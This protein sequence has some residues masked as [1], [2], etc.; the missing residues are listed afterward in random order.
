M[1]DNNKKKGKTPFY[2]EI[3]T[4]YSYSTPVYKRTNKKKKQTNLLY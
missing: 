3:K 2:E 4:N 1:N